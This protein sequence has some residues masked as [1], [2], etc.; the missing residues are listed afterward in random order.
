MF[1]V[2]ESYAEQLDVAARPDVMAR[3]AADS[4]GAVIDSADAASVADQFEQHIAKTRPQRVRQLTAWDRW[5]IL[6]GVLCVWGTAWGLRR[7]G[8][9]I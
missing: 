6:V 8:G 9:L 4:G 7:S 3:I 2:R 1:D 5:W